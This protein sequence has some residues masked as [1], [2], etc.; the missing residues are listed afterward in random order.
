M[1]LLKALISSLLVVAAAAAPAPETKA[2]ALG[3]RDTKPQ[4]THWSIDN[5]A[6]SEGSLEETE[7]IIFEEDEEVDGAIAARS[8]LEARGLTCLFGGNVACKIK[9]VRL[10]RRKGGSCN[11]KG[12][13]VCKL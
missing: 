7:D 9:C 10:G 1:H 5:G 12:T 2:S 3:L 6:S 4:D 8:A 13:C 11:K